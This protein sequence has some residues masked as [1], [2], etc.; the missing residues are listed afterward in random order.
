VSPGR[1]DF[2]QRPGPT[3]VAALCLGST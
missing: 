2:R 1:V 3:Q